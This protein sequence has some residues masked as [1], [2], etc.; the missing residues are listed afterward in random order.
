MKN[1]IIREIK[2]PFRQLIT[3]CGFGK[4]TRMSDN[5]INHDKELYTKLNNDPRFEIRSEYEWIC[6]DDKYAENGSIMD[7]SY[8][9]QDIWGARKVFLNKPKIHY[10][11]GSLVVGFIAHLLSMNQRV[12]LI[13]VRAMNN[14]FDT[15]F[16]NN[17]RHGLSNTGGGGVLA[18]SNQM[19]PT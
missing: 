16:I 5:E 10:D 2:R 7:S 17:Y 9:I 4:P 12:V 13:D 3:K 18:I 8:F 1:K 15:D 11:V 14:D 6:R 19:P